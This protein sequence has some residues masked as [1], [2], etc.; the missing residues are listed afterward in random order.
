MGAKMR[1]IP[2]T[3]FL[4]PREE[5]AVT[6]VSNLDSVV[7]LSDF[8]EVITSVKIKAVMLFLGPYRLQLQD[9]FSFY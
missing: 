8:L 2:P 6:F 9:F 3:K 7:S 5:Q 4:A 1:W